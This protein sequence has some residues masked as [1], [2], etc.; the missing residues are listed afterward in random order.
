MLQ[1]NA[2]ERQRHHGDH[3][4]RMLFCISMHRVN[5]FVEPMRANYHAAAQKRN[6]FIDSVFRDS[7]ISQKGSRQRHNFHFFLSVSIC[8]SE[9]IFKITKGLWIATNID[10]LLPWRSL[11]SSCSDVSRPVS[12]PHSTF[13][14][15]PA[16][17]WETQQQTEYF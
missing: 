13:G 8:L 3:S 10:Q 14:R 12:R 5:R 2:V 17:T 16:A 9:N 6:T 15:S 11:K 4:F 7:R 1:A